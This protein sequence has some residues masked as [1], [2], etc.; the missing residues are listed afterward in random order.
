M[1]GVEKSRTFLTEFIIVILFNWGAYVVSSVLV[2]L[3]VIVELYNVYFLGLFNSV[4]GPVIVM[5]LFYKSEPNVIVVIPSFNIPFVK[6]W[7]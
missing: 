3:N 6:Y 5:F 2:P 1:N 4:N 7:L